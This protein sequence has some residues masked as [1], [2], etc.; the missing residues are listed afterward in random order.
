M[1]HLYSIETYNLKKYFGDVLAVDNLNLR[2][3]TGEI[4]GFLGPNGAGK[5]TTIRLLT[6]TLRPT[7]GKVKILGMDIETQEI[8]I[9]RSIG[10]VPDE[11]RLYENLKGKEFIDFVI[12][13]YRLNRSSILEKL[14]ELCNAFDVNYLDGYIGDY[15]HGM[16][17]KLMVISVLL[18]NPRIIFLDEPTVGLDAKSVRLLKLLLK[19]YVKEGV[20]IFITTHILEI[21]EKM[22]D[23]IGIINKG[24]LIAE[25]TLEELKTL[26]SGGHSNLEDLF[27]ELTGQENIDDILSALQ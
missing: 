1:E 4:Y 20:T 27:L 10:V 18:R 14:T 6:G 11:P 15:S 12:D 5:T 23:R 17:Q 2:I 26:S 8:D 7:S 9:K 3:K 24:K 16:K 13:V 25:G 19:R 21:A 22:C